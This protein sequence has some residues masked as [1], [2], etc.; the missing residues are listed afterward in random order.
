MKPQVL[1]VIS[2]IGISADELAKR[3]KR[4]DVTKLLSGDCTI[5][6]LAEI[7]KCLNIPLKYFY[8]DNYMK[9]KSPGKI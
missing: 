6:D 1:E 5:G 9:I 2:R 3:M 7:G 4:K 8:D